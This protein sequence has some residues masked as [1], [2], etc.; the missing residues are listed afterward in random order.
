M[1]RMSLGSNESMLS[2]LSDDGYMSRS[3]GIKK[4]KSRFANQPAREV[5]SSSDSGGGGL[6][7]GDETAQRYVG[8]ITEEERLQRCMKYLKKKYSKQERYVYRCR[9]KVADKRLR[10]KGRFV[11][12]EQAYELLGLSQQ[13]LRGHQQLQEML[14][15][16]AE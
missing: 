3:R 9:A 16:L 15:K 13:D 10:V 6:Q 4:Q 12:K 1:R 8:A 2:R 11:T 14:N 7:Y 5:L